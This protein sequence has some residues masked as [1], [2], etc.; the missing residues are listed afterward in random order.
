MTDSALLAENEMLKAQLKAQASD[1]EK[2]S[3][4]HERADALNDTV[5][6]LQS[7]LAFQIEECTLMA[8]Q[9]LRLH[10]A[11]VGG[12]EP[13][14]ATHDD[15]RQIADRLIQCKG[16]LDS[17]LEREKVTSRKLEKALS[18]IDEQNSEFSRDAKHARRS[19]NQRGRDGGWDA[20]ARIWKDK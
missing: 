17:Q 10:T 20:A 14:V 5:I 3:R 7:S 4:S 11:V 6:S 18:A 8:Q 1:L 19:K 15:C 2:H 13:I 16:F 9:F 12:D